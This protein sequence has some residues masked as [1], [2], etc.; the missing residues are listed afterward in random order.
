MDRIMATFLMVLISNIKLNITKIDLQLLLEEGKLAHQEVAIGCI[1]EMLE[2]Q[3]YI[4][5]Q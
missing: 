1:R 4:N 3:F 5:N 2:H